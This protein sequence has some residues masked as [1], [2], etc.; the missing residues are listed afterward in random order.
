MP[1]GHLPGWNWVPPTGAA[2]RP[3][4]APRWLRW[5]YRTPFLDRW[6]YAVMWHRGYWEVLPAPGEPAGAPAP[7]P[8]S[9]QAPS[10]QEMAAK[11]SRP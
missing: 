2:P 1:P 9:P 3:D 4:L 11:S 5:A 7:T 10:H 6:A 8:P